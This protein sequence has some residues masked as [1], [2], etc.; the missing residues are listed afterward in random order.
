MLPKEAIT[1]FKKLYKKNYGVELSDEEAVFRANN[2]VN[3]YKAVYSDPPFGRVETR[4]KKQPQE[5]E[6]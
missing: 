4:D 3:F 6:K 2:F 5:H 1:E